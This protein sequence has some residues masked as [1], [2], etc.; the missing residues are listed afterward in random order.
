MGVRKDSSSLSLRK[1]SASESSFA[2][3]LGLLVLLIAIYMRLMNYDLRRDEHLYVPPA[4][5]LDHYELYRDFF[6]NHVP[7]SAWFFHIVRVVLGTDHLLFSARL[8]VF[9]AWVFLA[10][11]VAWVNCK[12][13]NSRLFAAFS[14]LAIFTNQ[15]FLGVAGMTATNN[16]LPLPLAY[17]GIGLFVLSVFGDRVYPRET[18]V[19]GLL[20][21]LAAS[22]KA[23]A[24]AFIIPV[25]LAAF[26][27]PNNLS[28]P[29]RLRRVVLPL[30]I[31][32]VL[33]ALP[34]F[35]YLAK[36]PA[37]FFAHVTGFH[38]GP[39]IAYW[40]AQVDKNIDAALSLPD[41]LKLAYLVWTGGSNLLLMLGLVLLVVLRLQK[42]SGAG[43]WRELINAPVI[44]VSAVLATVSAMSFLP[45]PA[46]PQYFTP[47]IIGASLLLTVLYTGLGSEGRKV[48][49]PV[50]IAA[51]M[52]LVLIGLPRLTQYL[53]RLPD[54]A[55]WTVTKVHKAGLEIAENLSLNGRDGKLATIA[56]V[57]PLEGNLPVYPELATGQFIYRSAGYAG[58]DLRRYYR[59]TSP[60]EIERLFERDPPAGI[61]T[62]FESELE[63]PMVEYAR[64][65]GYEKIDELD[66]ED[67]YGK[68]VLY[69][70]PGR[71]LEKR[72]NPGS[73]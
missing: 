34:V 64:K 5:L 55:S 59:T 42:D 3:A 26:L 46:F 52:V 15:A 45:T 40:S 8:G 14:V 41:K 62:G 60:D 54:P 6:Y 43:R 58:E 36:G 50:L 61:L 19:S 1:S 29:E 7:V 27:V 11:S 68:G 20:L 12:L 63:A 66:L 23:S 13:T 65:N 10:V 48:M 9:A 38:L 70:T 71:S 33:G 57:Y 47:P 49:R 56:P 31:G 53:A 30:F 25:A 51:G 18:A 4:V 67:R 21:A 44:V 2:L 37:R 24:I 69:V 32:G 28:F 72:G 35:L 16:F 22:V 39:H 17:L 73:G